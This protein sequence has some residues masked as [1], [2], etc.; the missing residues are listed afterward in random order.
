MKNASDDLNLYFFRTIYSVREI[1]A[2]L[3]KKKYPY[4]KKIL[5]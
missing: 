3:P 4:K 2:S 1:L 5:A